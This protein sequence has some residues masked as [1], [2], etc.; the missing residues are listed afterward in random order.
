MNTLSDYRTLVLGM[1]GD[2]AGRRY[3]N[4]MLDLALR[5]ALAEWGTYLPGTW[6]VRDLDDAPET[7]VEDGDSMTL[8][9]GAA[10]F[11]MEIRARSVTEVFGKRPE[12]TERLIE[13]ADGLKKQ[14]ETELAGLSFRKSLAEDPWPEKGWTERDRR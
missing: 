11:A 2:P 13:Q 7:A 14:F 3:S 1:L 12:D 8:T 6:T 4:D 9:K 5:Q 10:A